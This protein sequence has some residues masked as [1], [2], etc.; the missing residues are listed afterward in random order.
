MTLKEIEGNPGEVGDPGPF[1]PQGGAVEGYNYGF[2]PGQWYTNWGHLDVEY[3]F[4]SFITYDSALMAQPFLVPRDTDFELFGAEVITGAVGSQIMPGIYRDNGGGAPGELFVEG[5]SMSTAS[6]G[7]K[8][9]GAGGS[10]GVGAHLTRGLYWLASILD[11]VDSTLRMRA[12]YPRGQ[13]WI[14][15]HHIGQEGSLGVVAQGTFANMPDP[16]PGEGSNLITGFH[17]PKV[18]LKAAPVT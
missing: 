15:H 4:A 7:L 11:L 14:M 12:L 17:V 9:N 13:D 2:K 16:F 1:G 18:M 8:F 5:V 10:P 6:P 3:T